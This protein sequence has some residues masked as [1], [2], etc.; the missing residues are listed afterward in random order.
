VKRAQEWYVDPYS[1]EAR[2]V[3][4]MFGEDGNYAD[5][6]LGVAALDNTRLLGQPGWL[7]IE[8]YM[9]VQRV[10]ERDEWARGGV[11]NGRT[12]TDRV[13]IERM[14]EQE[15]NAHDAASGLTG[16]DP[17]MFKVRAGLVALGT[18]R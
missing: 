11:W 5:F 1:P 13:G 9:R 12:L 18:P 7:S 17:D 8:L 2:E 6:H 4:D 10:R 16:V 15:P 3:R 14:V